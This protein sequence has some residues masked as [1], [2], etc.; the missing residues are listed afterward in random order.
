MKHIL[1]VH[2][3]AELYGSDKTLLLFL[4][5]LDRK[6]IVPTVILPSEGPLKDEINLLN[7][8]VSI[9][10]V[11]KLHR[12]LFK[13]KN[14]L[15]F[16]SDTYCSIKFI[17][18]LD[19]ENHF[20]YIYSNTIAVLAGFIYSFF[21]NKKHIW[22]VHEIIENPKIVKKIFIKLLDSKSNYKVIFNSKQT[23]N[24]W[25]KNTKNLHNT[26]ELIWNGLDF[27]EINK[28]TD[29]EISNFRS[30]IISSDKDLILCLVGR[31]NPQKGQLFLLEAF[32]I[33]SKKNKNIK[34][35][36]VGSYLS[37]QKNYYNLLEEFIISNNLSEMVKIIPF[38]KNIWN[39]WYSI[40]IALVPSLYLEPFG[41][42][43]I[44]AMYAEKP[45]IVSAHGGLLDIVEDNKNG[46]LSKPLQVNDLV[47]KIQLLIDNPKIREKLALKGK[48]SVIKRFSIEEHMNH[49][50]KI[51]N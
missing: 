11:L 34:L 35:L 45:V 6:R 43:A 29:L 49:F 42:V 12:N 38:Q 44:E 15:K 9:Q 27:K 13:P 19:K 10:P 46:L 26:G 51:L 7:I 40:D 16:I 37:N 48:N 21:Y 4:K 22:H 36:L 2:Q 28:P 23:Q 33:L 30:E 18:K 8:P 39:I 20:D 32:K 50:Y 14:F 3:S 5:N 41:L 47:E 31:F 24:F 1:I 25:L 17:K